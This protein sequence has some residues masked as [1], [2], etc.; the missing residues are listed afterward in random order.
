MFIFILIIQ[1][2][3]TI[4]LFSFFV[5]TVNFLI[6]KVGHW[7]HVFGCCFLFFNNSVKAMYGPRHIFLGHMVPSKSEYFW[8]GSIFSNLPQSSF[9]HIV[10]HK[11]I[12]AVK[13]PIL[14]FTDLSTYL[15]Q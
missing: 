5:N 12:S 1:K 2:I 15:F 9:L 7:I 13:F 4:Y 3:S 10:L 6:R 11:P 14:G 8:A